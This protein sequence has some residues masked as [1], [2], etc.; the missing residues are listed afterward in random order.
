MN[1]QYTITGTTKKTIKKSKIFLVF[2]NNE[3]IFIGTFVLLF[4]SICKTTQTTQNST[5]FQYIH[6]VLVHS[7]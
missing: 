4:H 2:L 3:T 7:F 1:I 5:L 6:S